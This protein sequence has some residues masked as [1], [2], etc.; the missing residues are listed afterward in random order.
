MLQ[1]K[2]DPSC[3][4]SSSE[5]LQEA[6][7]QIPQCRPQR[8]VVAHDVR[9]V[10]LQLDQRVFSLQVQDV[11]VC[12]LLHLHFCDAVLQAATGEDNTALKSEFNPN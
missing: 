5:F 2:I 1:H 9:P 4:T 10:L 7:H 11:T 6:E 8:L 12:R 3:Q